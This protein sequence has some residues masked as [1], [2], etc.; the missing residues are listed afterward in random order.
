[1]LQVKTAQNFSDRQ[2]CP[3]LEAFEIPFKAFGLKS[4]IKTAFNPNFAR[5]VLENNYNIHFDTHKDSE[6]LNSLNKI[7]KNLVLKNIHTDNK[8]KKQF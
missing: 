6:I 8:I 1:M 3:R 5:R 4:K 2:I 7:Y